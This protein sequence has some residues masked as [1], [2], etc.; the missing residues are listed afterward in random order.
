MAT[1]RTNDIALIFNG[2]EP[3]T[4]ERPMLR[5]IDRNRHT[6]EAAKLSQ[7][8]RLL[9]FSRGSSDITADLAQ[10]MTMITQHVNGR[11]ETV[12]QVCLLG[13][14]DG[15]SLALAVAAE[16]NARGVASLSYVGLSDVTMFAAGRNPPVPKIGALR[17][18]NEPQVSSGVKRDNDAKLGLGGILQ[19]I[20]Y[21]FPEVNSTPNITL[22]TDI[23]AKFKINHFQTL[24]NHVKHTRDG[25]WIWFSDMA[26]GEV[27]G[28]IDGW[29]N[30]FFIGVGNTDLEVHVALNLLDP[31]LQLGREATDALVDFPADAR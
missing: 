7:P 31:W 9:A 20:H 10:V 17:T 5:D 2:G 15:C 19:R 8:R 4:F 11:F 12:G 28:S 24:G 21:P 14:S 30:R 25:R 23:V 3:F 22:D 1:I 26:G 29:E 16:L 13:R 18:N 27:H 6:R